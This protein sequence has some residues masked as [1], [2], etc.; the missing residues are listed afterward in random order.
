MH[1][2]SAPSTFSQDVGVGDFNADG[3]MD[4]VIAAIGPNLVYRGNGNGGFTLQSS[5]GTANS[6]AVAVGRFDGDNKDDLVFA[7][8]GSASRVWVYNAS[9]TWF[10]SRA[11][12]A[13]GDAVGVTTGEFSGD[14]SADLAFARVPSAIG[15]VPANPV[16]IN[17]G[18][19]TFAPSATLLGSAPTSDIFAGNVNDIDGAGRDDLVFI[20][21]SGVHQIWVANGSGG[22]N[23][24]SEQIADRGS[25]A[26]V[27]A[28]LGMTDI[29]DPGGFDLAM[30]G[31]LQSGVGIFLNDG[32]GNLGKGDAVPPVLTLL[33]A[34]VTEVPSGSSYVDAGATALDNISGDISGSIAV[35][36]SVNTS[37]VGTYTVTYNVSDFAG[38]AA[39][40]I[41]RTVN[42]TPSA[43]TGGGGGGSI[44]YWALI[45][46]LGILADGFRRRLNLQVVYVHKRMRN[47]R[48]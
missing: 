22:F 47:K 42:V 6:H 17:N 7:N 12:L 37:V 23:L 18:N 31:A 36:A 21:S 28:E 14:N 5:L 43:G 1:T 19:G 41:T 29:G 44:S 45:F 2:L 27:L 46:M 32:F 24:H 15:D 13:I 48:K 16:L 39:T 11:L 33:G 34:A 8:T 10:A 35:T 30:G 9:S 20:N 40:P 25:F 4:I 26:G 3:N 38:N